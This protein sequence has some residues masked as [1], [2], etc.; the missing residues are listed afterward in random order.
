M[1]YLPENGKMRLPF[2]ALSGVG[3]KAAYSIYEAAQKGN[4]ISKEEFL[5]S[6]SPLQKQFVQNLPFELTDDQRYVVHVM[7]QEIDCYTYKIN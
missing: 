2:G 7:N 4:F 5:A 6:L 1:K 3:E